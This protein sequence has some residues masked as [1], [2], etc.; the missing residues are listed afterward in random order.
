MAIAKDREQGEFDDLFL[1]DDYFSDLALKVVIGL[2]QGIYCFNII[3]V[4]TRSELLL[5]DEYLKI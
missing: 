1:T 2:M 4:W 5:R 3:C